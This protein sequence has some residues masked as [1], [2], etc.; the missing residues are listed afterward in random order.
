RDIPARRRRLQGT[1]L[2]L[3]IRR[4]LSTGE[5]V[6]VEIDWS[7][8]VPDG[9]GAP[10]TGQTDGHE[11]FLAYWYPQVAVCEDVRGWVADPYL[12]PGEFY[13]EHADYEL[14]LTLP[15]GFLVQATGRL[16]NAD[17]VLPTAVL[18]RLKQA[19]DSRTRV[20]IV[21]KEDLEAGTATRT[22]NEDGLLTWRFRAE[23][24]RDLSVALSDR[25]VWDAMACASEATTAAGGT[26]AQAFYRPEMRGWD[27]AA[28]FAQ[29][30]IEWM[31]GRVGAYPW[32][33]MSVIEGAAGGGMEFPMMTLIGMEGE[34]A[35]L[36]YV[37]CHETIH[38]WFPMM[39]GSDE[40]SWG[41]MD[42]G[43]TTF[44]Q[45]LCQDAFFER[46]NHHRSYFARWRRRAPSAELTICSCHADRFPLDT[47][48]LGDAVYTKPCVALHQLRF[49]LGD[50]IFFR[51]LRGYFE[52]WNGRHPHPI[53]LY[54]AFSRLAG[55]DLAWYFQIWFEENWYLDTAIAQ[56]ETD[57]T[58][59]TVTLED[60]GRA[61][62]PTVVDAEFPGGRHERQSVPVSVWGAGVRRTTVRF[63]G[64]PRR[65]QLDPDDHNLDVD[66]SNDAWPR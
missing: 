8:K 63:E 21:R 43:I 24:V 13:M 34:A 49:L 39:V 19:A 18:G 35:T 15:A 50:E 52:E 53:D 6:V 29:H 65:F 56:V 41:F 26:L 44:L 11:F 55:Q 54:R 4:G 16:V 51:A 1:V 32:P 30:A 48:D 42:E 14:A 3:P 33:H 58:G 2:T 46:D 17:E 23:Q 37:V 31:A 45:Q 47:P 60:R 25:Y 40:K 38:M 5:E 27:R 10:R 20:E 12:G 57:A 9:G 7:H 22:G 61:F 28:E 36:Q 64:F 59:T 62:H 66:R